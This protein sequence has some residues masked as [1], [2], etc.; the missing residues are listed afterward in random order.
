MSRVLQSKLFTEDEVQ[1]IQNKKSFIFHKSLRYDIEAM[2]AE[3]VKFFMEVIFL[4]VSDGELL[5]L[6]PESNRGVR[7]AFNRFYDDY[8]RDNQEWLKT[9]KQKSIAGK[10]SAEVRAANK[11]NNA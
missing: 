8:I 3:E 7:V 1:K 11:I 5:D 10:K 6:A 9:C 2:S 4:F